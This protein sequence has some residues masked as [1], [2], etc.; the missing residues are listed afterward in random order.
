M[1]AAV[2]VLPARARRAKAHARAN[3]RLTAIAVLSK[4]AAVLAACGRGVRMEDAVLWADDEPCAGVTAASE[5]RVFSVLDGIDHTIEVLTSQ[6]FAP[7]GT[8]EQ[9]AI[10]ALE[11]RMRLHVRDGQRQR[12]ADWQIERGMTDGPWCAWCTLREVPEVGKRCHV[13]AAGVCCAA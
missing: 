13:C 6:M 12:Y 10:I 8:P 9:A 5:I 1:S 7:D 4:V 3:E 2:S 11:I